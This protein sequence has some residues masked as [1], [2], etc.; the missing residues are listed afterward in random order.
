MRP[1]RR[2]RAEL[3]LFGVEVRRPSSGELLPL[4]V[5]LEARVRSTLSIGEI[6]PLMEEALLS[7]GD[8][9]P[10]MDGSL[11]KD[12]LLLAEVTLCLREREMGDSLCRSSSEAVGGGRATGRTSPRRPC[13]TRRT[14]QGS[15]RDRKCSSVSQPPPTRTI[16]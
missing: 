11:L 15:W 4:L 5:L 14:W 1:D 13:V 7:T 2:L 8:T 12:V 16:M 3:G 9:V 6:L 10:A